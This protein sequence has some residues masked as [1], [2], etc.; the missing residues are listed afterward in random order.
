MIALG[1]RVVVAD[2]AD[3]HAGEHG[4]VTVAEHAGVLTGRPMVEVRVD[5]QPEQFDL[6]YY[7]SQV[8]VLVLGAVA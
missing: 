6:G 8:D 3:L 7:V 1:A 5:G 2:Y 4:T